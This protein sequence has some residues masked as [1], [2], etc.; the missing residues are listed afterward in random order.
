MLYQWKQQNKS[1]EHWAEQSKHKS[2]TMQTNQSVNNS[3]SVNGDNCYGELQILN[4]IKS[5]PSTDQQKIQHNWQCRRQYAKFGENCSSSGL[6]GTHCIP[7]FCD[8]FS[9]IFL[10]HFHRSDW[11]KSLCAKYLRKLK[12]HALWGLQKYIYTCD[13]CLTPKQSFLYPKIH[14]KHFAWNC[15]TMRSREGVGLGSYST[16]G[17]SGWPLLPR[18]RVGYWAWISCDDIL[19]LIKNVLKAIYPT[20]IFR[21]P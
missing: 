2:I 13:Q 15:F 1:K 9:N 11:R 12:G 6:L 7:W 16:G 3:H 14:L 17:T 20:C 10:D 8:F 4:P 5:K 19:R 18:D 21:N